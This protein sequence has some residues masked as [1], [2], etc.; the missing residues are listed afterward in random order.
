M[1]VRIGLDCIDL[2]S[3][4]YYTQQ[5]SYNELFKHRNVIIWLS[6]ISNALRK[7][8]ACCRYTAAS[9]RGLNWTKELRT[10]LGEL[11]IIHFRPVQYF[12]I[13]RNI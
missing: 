11:G 1:I 13:F 2:F 10:L 5:L 6:S 9:S 7:I 8:V 3:G 4:S 12:P